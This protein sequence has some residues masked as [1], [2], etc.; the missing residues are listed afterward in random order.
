MKK[1]AFLLGISMAIFITANVVQATQIID[2]TLQVNSLKVGSQGVGGVTFFNG[3]IVNETTGDNN[4]NNPVTFGD[5]VR[6]DGR[7]YRGATAGTS[8]SQPFIINDNAEIDGSLTVGKTLSAGAT[9]ISGSLTANRALTANSA[10]VTNDL[11]VGG[12]ASVDG[13]LTVDGDITADG[14]PMLKKVVYTGKFDFDDDGDYQM[15]YGEYTYYW[16][17]VNVPE[18]DLSDMPMVQVATGSPIEATEIYP[19]ID[20]SFVN[21]SYL[22]ANYMYEDGK[23]HILYKANLDDDEDTPLYTTED[24]KIVVIY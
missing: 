17:T 22:V 3:T 2:D 12:D 15:P 23:V 9:T 5:N 7:V 14:S 13:D 1:I 16:I 8:D 18:I 24:Y 4:A 20:D 21:N 6:I 11:T 19:E 10:T